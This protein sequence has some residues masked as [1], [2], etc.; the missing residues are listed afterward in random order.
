MS[1]D[2]RELVLQSKRL[3]WNAV[4]HAGRPSGEAERSAIVA[5]LVAALATN[6]PEMAC[7]EILW[8]LSEI[9]GD[10]SVDAVAATLS[11]ERLRDDARMALERIPGNKSL[12][13]LET[14][15]AQAP[16]EF[17]ANLAQSLRRR[18]VAVPGYPCQKLIPTKPTRVRAIS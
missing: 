8:M 2:D 4:R 11:H 13:A 5:E 1:S 10:E 3:L 14:G 12:A 18:G 7:R 9:G 16:E 15:L 17:R 6:L